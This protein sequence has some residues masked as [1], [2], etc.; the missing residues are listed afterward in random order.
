MKGYA[1]ITGA[2]SGF[3]EAIAES[4][5]KE[6]FQLIIAARRTERLIALKERL[7]GLCSNIHI[8]SMDVRQEA[9]VQ[10]AISSLPTEVKNHIEILVNNAGLAVGRGPIDEG[11]SEDWERMIDT[12]IKGLLYVTKAVVPFLKLQKHGHIVNIASIAGKEVYPGGNVYCASKHA[13]DALSRSMRIDLISYG[14]K[15]TNIAPGAAETEFSLVRFKGDQSTADSVYEG[16]DALQAEDIAESV[17]F[18]VTRPAHVNISD[19]TIMPTAQA[20]ASIFHKDR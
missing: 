9:A 3:G 13:V 15:V 11:V 8:L 7:S 2:S 14:I 5:A 10:D 18:A 19:I 4:L 17:L 12:N 16:Y 1:F 6:G 20:S